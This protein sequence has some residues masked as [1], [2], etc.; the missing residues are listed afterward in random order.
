MADKRITELPSSVT[1]DGTE[2]VPIVQ[3]G[4]TSQATTQDI[5]DLGGGSQDLQSVTDAGN[6]TTNDIQFDTGVGILLDNTSR[7]R[8]GTIDAGY[9]GA[10]GIS[11]ICAV[12]YE[13]KW[14]SG[15]LYVMDGNG[16][17]IRHTLYNFSSVPSITEDINKGFLV[18]T[19]WSLDNGDSY[20]CTD[21]S[22]GA[23]V[24]VLQSNGVPTLAQVLAS[25][26]Q[27]GGNPISSDD[28]NQAIYVDNTYLTLDY[29]AGTRGIILSPTE[30][31]I[32][33]DIIY[34]NGTTSVQKNGVEIATIDDIIP[35]VNS[36]W[37]A[38][39]GVKE[40]L[41]KP[42]IPTQV[43]P[44]GGTT[45]Q[46]LAKVD[47]TDY[48]LEWI[49]NY[50]NYTSVL[51]HTV[52]ASVALTKGQAV[53]VSGASGTN[54]LVSKASNVSE[55]TSSKTLGLIAQNLAING[56]GFVITEGLLSGLNTNSATIGDPVWLG[57]DGALIYGLASKPY[58]PAHLVFIGIVTR[59]SATVG[60]IFVKVQNGFELREIHD[61]DL[62]TTSPSNNEILTYES[63][64]SLWK[65][66]SV[67]TALGYTAENVANKDATGGY[68]GLT[69]FKINFKNVLNTFTSFF[70]NSNTA[71]RTYTFQD[72]NGTIADN[73]DLGTKQ[74]TLVSLTN[75]RTVNG[76][77][78]LGSTNL[79]VGTILG[80]VGATATLGTP[81]P[82]GSGV[83]NT[84]TST[85]FIASYNSGAITYRILANTSTS[86]Q[87]AYIFEENGQY[88][89]LARYGSA[90]VASAF[91]G[92]SVVKSN[93]LSIESGN[94]LTY[95]IVLLGSPI[96]HGIAT[97]STN[98]ATRH[99]AT[100]W[101]VGTMADVHTANTVA[102]EVSGKAKF[103]ST[104][105]LKGYTVATLPT[106][107]EGDT[108]YVTDAL[109][110]TYLVAVVG[111]GAIK[112]KVFFNG[113]N[114]IT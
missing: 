39:S 7:L 106:G 82:Y 99:D 46:I 17:H 8:E 84:L 95:P 56:Q 107:V 12:G 13:L 45:G 105:R 3:G 96:I 60:E 51:K 85:P 47:D 70:T 54:M 57:V 90:F 23:A 63:S 65:N 15:S 94:S 52:K 6:T 26:L 50:A 103:N 16:T 11:Q 92:M 113:T 32:Y 64:T 59:V 81:S 37:N 28:G 89:R 87:Q 58:A 1:L 61:V 48:N 53:Y 55:A 110:P 79:Q 36:D 31:Q 29:N 18:G 21:N 10:K 49:E 101:R 62:I 34:L 80:S 93:V 114:W 2:I 104:I 9:G 98:V 40:I 75:I 19:R 20:V 76:S 27:T 108:A 112:C 77:T 83:A 30:T 100:G 24:W 44:V 67:A 69:L 43:V 86:Q 22:I 14:E 5:A 71:A 35:Q 25:G 38:T 33:G 73:T 66:K 68:A 41:N 72:R 4:V 109:A 88:S 97:T 91:T 111:G 42:T 102:F 78:L 74:D